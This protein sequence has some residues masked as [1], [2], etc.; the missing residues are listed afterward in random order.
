MYII[1][2]V[3]CGYDVLADSAEEMANRKPLRVDCVISNFGHSN[4]T[5]CSREAALIDF[6]GIILS[7]PD[8]S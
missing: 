1:A 2:C 4:A 3:D 8:A 6:R 5:Q 7:T